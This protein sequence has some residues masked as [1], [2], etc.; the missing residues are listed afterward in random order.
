MHMDRR[1]SAEI[2]RQLDACV[3][4]LRAERVDFARELVAVAS[5]NPP[6]SAYPECVRI[7]E[8]RLRNLGLPSERIHAGAHERRRM[9]CNPGAITLRVTVLG[10]EAHVGLLHQGR[11]AFEDALRVVAD[12]QNWLDAW[13]VGVRTSVSRP[14]RPDDR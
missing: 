3:E 9:E 12:L 2:C 10:R 4:G 14:K 5:E 7:I 13:G 1:G 6:R 11:N 8:A